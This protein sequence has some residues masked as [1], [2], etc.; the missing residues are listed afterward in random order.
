MFV[1][2]HVCDDVLLLASPPEIVAVEAGI[3]VEEEVIDGYSGVR[4]HAE[5]LVER[6]VNLMH[7]VMLAGLRLGYGNRKT[8]TVR[9]I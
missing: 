7:V 9:Y 3:R 4:D 5:K 1:E 2:V 6:S 8:L